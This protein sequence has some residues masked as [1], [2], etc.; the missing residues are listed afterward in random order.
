MCGECIYIKTISQQKT[1]KAIPTKKD[2]NESNKQN[3]RMGE[4]ELVT[5]EKPHFCPSRQ[6]I[7]IKV[8]PKSNS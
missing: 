6:A 7:G 3:Y 1:R 5:I 2:D 8:F 4:K